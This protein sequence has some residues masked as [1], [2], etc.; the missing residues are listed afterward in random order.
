MN[1]PTITS[2]YVFTNGMTAVFDSEGKQV[3]ELQ[4]SWNEKR[5]AIMRA[6]SDSTSFYI[7][8]RYQAEIP[9]TKQQAARLNI[10]MDEASVK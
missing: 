3:P 7:S 8:S 9:L 1:S 5:E 6:A 4:G 10:S 2:V